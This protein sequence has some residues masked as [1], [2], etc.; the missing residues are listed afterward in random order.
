MGRF[1]ILAL[2]AA[3]ESGMGSGIRMIDE[4]AFRMAGSGNWWQEGKREDSGGRQT[5]F[6]ILSLDPMLQTYSVPLRSSPVTQVVLSKSDSQRCSS[7]ILS[8]VQRLVVS[9]PFVRW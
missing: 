7:P 1:V 5:S 4:L 3:L 6:R 8:H 2:D 9:V